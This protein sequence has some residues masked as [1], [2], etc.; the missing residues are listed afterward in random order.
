MLSISNPMK[1]ADAAVAYYLDERKENY[2]L[3]G[4]DKQGHWFG[5]AA[6]PLGLSGIVEREPF[7]NL[8]DGFSP[9]GSKALVQNAGKSDRQA[10][11]DMTFNAPKAVSVFWAMSTPEVRREIEAIHR[12]S[13]ETSLE[14]AEQVG[15]ITR[16][17]PGGRIH[18]RAEL[19]WATFQEGTSRAQDPHLHTH[20]VLLN[21]AQRADGTTG[22]LHSTN[23]FR[24]KMALGAIY[25]AEVAARLQNQLGLEIEPAKSA[26]DIRGVPQSLCQELSKRR[27][28]IEKA[29]GERG[30][31]GALEAKTA[32]KDTRPG[33]EE[34]SPSL[35]FARWQESG[36]AFG[37][38]VKQ[39]QELIRPGRQQTVSVEQ[40]EGWVREAVASVPADKQHRSPVVREAARIAL[41]H[42]ADGST[43]FECLT[44]TE[45]AEG[46]KVLW[47]PRESPAHP[48]SHDGNHQD[49]GRQNAPRDRANSA[50]T[51]IKTAV[52][53]QA[54]PATDSSRNRMTREE[55]SDG[56]TKEV[57]KDTPQ[58]G[59]AS[60]G[61]GR[62]ASGQEP[63]SRFGPGK[64][65]ATEAGPSASEPKNDSR[66]K[67]HGAAQS[68]T[69]GTASTHGGGQQRKRASGSP[70]NHQSAGN[71]ARF[72]WTN[73]DVS[74]LDPR[75]VRSPSQRRDLIRKWVNVAFS[76]SIQTPM[77]QVGSRT[78]AQQARTNHRFLRFF[79]R[80]MAGL[81]ANRR[82]LKGLTRL[83]VR[84]ACRRG[85]DPQTVHAAIRT[86]RC[87]HEQ[88]RTGL[89]SRKPIFRVERQEV[90][91][92]HDPDEPCPIKVPVVC[93]GD[94][95]PTWWRIKWRMK[96]LPNVELRV[97]QRVLFPKVARWNPLRGLMVPALRVVTLK[98][99]SKPSKK[100][101][102]ADREADKDDHGQQNSSKSDTQSHTSSH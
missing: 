78:S 2:Y 101:A 9:D 76:D 83:A 49:E 4:I 64:T 61:P 35:L 46:G 94:R 13:V 67:G 32:A 65:A 93:I 37:W 17:G 42:G 98:P 59:Q 77:P 82:L 23:L 62:K 63:G 81:P 99:D 92:R 29:M 36:E 86:A 11:W 48:R 24:W 58:T 31:S 20:A 91:R 57:H 38:G 54:R 28:A 87:E 68:E 10:C 79:G 8:L 39:A 25:Q 1:S 19:L 6:Q 100:D 33:K 75:E 7:R 85:V 53:S 51:W 27:R 16:R 88:L 66:Q 52:H 97:Q 40:L 96:L 89:P 43:L 71:E 50:E 73:D 95:D 72:T 30:V 34:V 90:I 55:R 21:F 69:A 56:A 3:N 45:F 47:Q 22:S 26:F 102:K 15:G 74:R 14:K 41:R 12:Q 60:A 70:G 5:G 84:L 80:R 44:R 18:E